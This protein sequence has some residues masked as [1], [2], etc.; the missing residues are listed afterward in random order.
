MAVGINARLICG[1][2]PREKKSDIYVKAD[3]PPREALRKI[4]LA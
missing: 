1:K 2:T 4:W 3:F